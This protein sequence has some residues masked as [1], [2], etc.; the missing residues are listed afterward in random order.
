MATR[1]EIA[2][3]LKTTEANLAA[4]LVGLKIAPVCGRCGGSGRYS[5]NQIDG[6]RCY[7]CNG[8]G[9]VAPHD[10]DL[11]AMLEAALKASEDGRL[12]AYLEFLT[13]RRTTK[14][15]T[16]RVM[17]AW[18]AT[19]IS[20]TYDW[21]K[22]YGEN[23]NPR[24]RDIANINAK[25]AAAYDRVSKAAFALNPKR[26]TYQADVIA[27][28]TLVGEALDTIAAAKAELDAYLLT[29]EKEN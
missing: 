22:S 26:E 4:R 29:P 24:D 20:A 5:F 7:G 8:K 21:N 27:L 10:N 14:D 6:S 11:P 12:A 18:G 15:A 16:D 25:M 13:A 28:A 1:A 3:I 19:G 17:A 2:A 9:H 23:A